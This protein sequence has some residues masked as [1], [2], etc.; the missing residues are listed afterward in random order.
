MMFRQAKG[1]DRVANQTT[2]AKDDFFFF[3]VPSQN[4]GV[5]TLTLFNVISYCVRLDPTQ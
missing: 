2:A 3:L 5:V 1:T 4:N